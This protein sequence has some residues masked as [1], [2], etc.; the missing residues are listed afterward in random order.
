MDSSSFKKRLVLSLGEHTYLYL[1]TGTHRL[2]EGHCY[3]VPIRH[4]P[5][6]TACDEEI[7][8]EIELFKSSLR[9]M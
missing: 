4:T 6:S 7:W 1:A 3:I 5:A 2:S 8:R 9:K